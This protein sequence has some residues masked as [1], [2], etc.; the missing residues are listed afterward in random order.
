M[1]LVIF[2]ALIIFVI[3]ILLQFLK[4]FLFLKTE[5]LNWK[6]ILFQAKKLQEVRWRQVRWCRKWGEFFLRSK[7]NF[8][9]FLM[10][11]FFLNASTRSFSFYEI[12]LRYKSSKHTYF[13][14]NIFIPKNIL[15]NETLIR[16]ERGK[17]F[18]TVY[19]IDL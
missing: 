9:Q 12:S 7:V 3:W 2:E 16:N 11:I 8:F 6:K 19:K 10:R 14:N 17:C 5:I 15:W 18:F 1:F 13:S 4:K